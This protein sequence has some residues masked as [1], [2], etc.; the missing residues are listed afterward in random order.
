VQQQWRRSRGKSQRHGDTA[1]AVDTF[2]PENGFRSIDDGI[3]RTLT[4]ARPR[5]EN[6]DH[7]AATAENGYTTPTPTGPHRAAAPTSGRCRLS[8]DRLLPK[9]GG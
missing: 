4:Y 2:D 5:G 1:V 8:G 9:S 6:R 3:A 7:A